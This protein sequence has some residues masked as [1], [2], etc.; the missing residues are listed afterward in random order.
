MTD[1]LKTLARRA[2]ACKA[3]RWLPGMKAVGSRDNSAAWF[4]LEESVRRL[5]GDWASALPDFDDI[6]TLGCILS[7]VRAAYREPEIHVL[8]EMLSGRLVWT[9]WCGGPLRDRLGNLEIRGGSEI[10]ALV[11][12]LE[13]A[14]LAEA[15][16]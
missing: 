8:P 3:F 12:A 16:R 11:V 6:A 13:H 10:E 14:A 1:D 5:T 4:R 9:A 7:L 2:V 15:R